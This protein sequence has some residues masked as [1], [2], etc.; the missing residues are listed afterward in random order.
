[1]SWFLGWILIGVSVFC[2]LV[3]YEAFHL[4]FRAD[5]KGESAFDEVEDYQKQRGVNEWTLVKCLT[6]FVGVV[7]IWPKYRQEAGWW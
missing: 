1:M 6:W 4:K 5:K 2:L 3:V 7:L